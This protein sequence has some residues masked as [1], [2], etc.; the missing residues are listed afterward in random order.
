MKKLLLITIVLTS[1]LFV[2][3]EKEPLPQVNP[4]TTTTTTNTSTGSSS[5]NSSSGCSSAQCT[6]T[7]QAGNRCKRMTTNCSRRC[8]QH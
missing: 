8:Y 7:T 5:S 4:T 6:G 3:C 2:S 1:M